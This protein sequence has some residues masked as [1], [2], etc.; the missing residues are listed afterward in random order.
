M[1]ARF[2]SLRVKGRVRETADAVSLV[3]DVPEALRDHFVYSAGQF[4]TLAVNVDGQSH[5]RSYSMSSSPATD[6]D[7]VVTVKRVPGG[8]VSNWLNDGVREGDVLNVGRPGGSFILQPSGSDVIAFAAGSGITPVLSILKSA[9]AGTNRSVR[10]LYANRS[11][12]S[13]IFRAEIDDLAAARP[14]RLAVEHHFDDE[15]GFIDGGTVSRFVGPR[16]GS[17]FY[18]CGPAPFMDLVDATLMWNGV[19]RSQV[20]MERFEPVPAPTTGPL[21]DIEVV[22]TM[23]GRTVRTA[24][25]SR[26]TLLQTAR[27]AGLRAPSSCETGQCATCMARVVEGRAEMRHNGVLT[28]DEVA[29][30]WVLTCQAQPVTPVVK[31]VYE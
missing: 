16:L 21:D 27:L 26:S 3:L 10:V 18:I 20:H 17:E 7:L 28:D 8:A 15:R 5:L 19:R 24:H 9:L 6:A 1:S 4:V 25:R 30:G 22:L 29:E 23:G 2:H 31:V 13:T 14:D 12:D 11:R